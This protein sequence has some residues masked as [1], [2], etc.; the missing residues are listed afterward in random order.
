M[1]LSIDLDF[2]EE[3]EPESELL[4]E[5]DKSPFCEV[6]VYAKVPSFEMPVD[7]KDIL[8]HYRSVEI[9]LIKNIGGWL[10]TFDNVF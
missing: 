4:Q 3:T 10:A 5:I 2:E 6:S 1:Y 7:L 8:L 9:H